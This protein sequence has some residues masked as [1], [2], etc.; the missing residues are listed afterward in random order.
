MRLDDNT[1]NHFLK[2]LRAG[3]LTVSEVADEL[4]MWRSTVAYHAQQA[5]ID[6]I[7]A[8]KRYVR[9]M[10]ESQADNEAG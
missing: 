7:A 8:R 1:K 3:L 10:M 9:R 5:G 6:P 4:G 2:L